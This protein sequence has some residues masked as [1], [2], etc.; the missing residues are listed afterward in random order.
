MKLRDLAAALGCELR[1]DGD[2]EIAGVAPIEDAA[3]GTLTFLADR[4]LAAEL[5]TTR[6]AAVILPPDAPEVAL[7]SLRAPHPYLAF[8][9]AVDLFHPPPP[10]PAPGV[11]P[12]AVVA[13]SAI[14]GP[15]AW[16]GAHVVIG[17]GVCLGRD[18]TLHPHVT[19]YAGAEI[20]DGFTAHAGA[21]V[22]ERVRI[23]DRVVL[24]AGAIVGS[25]GFGYLPLPDGIRH[26]RHV[27][28]VVLEDE[29]EIGANATID[30]A[31]FGATVV[32]RGTKID[33]LVMV[34]HGCRLGPECLLAAQ[35]GLAGST[36]LGRRVMAGGQAGFAGH[37]RVGDG[38]QIAAQSGVP[39]DV[40]AGAVYA[41]YPATDVRVWRRVSGAI[42][43]LPMLFRRVRRLERVLGVGGAGSDEPV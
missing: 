20:G 7:A 24:H 21:V 14:V 26:I 17:D 35:V 42:V 36:T 29:V 23:G 4:R 16:I 28:T 39:G 43:R 40:P 3:P 31:A 38:A 9:A 6:A 12:S 41:G 27:G 32:G 22:R 18:A 13:S 11:H 10:R 15:G 30:R 2:V 19:L 34:A 25:D 33:N 5:A 8:I 37:Q 1:G